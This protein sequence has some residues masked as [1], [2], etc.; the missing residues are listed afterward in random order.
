[1]RDEVHPPA[2]TCR[3]VRGKGEGM[4][5]AKVLQRRGLGV[6]ATDIAAWRLIGGG[7]WQAIRSSARQRV[8]GAAARGRFEGS[9]PAAELRSGGG[10][11]LCDAVF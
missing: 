10:S 6:G 2:W 11:K 1:M 8:H 5:V 4:S 3:A 7:M 9:K